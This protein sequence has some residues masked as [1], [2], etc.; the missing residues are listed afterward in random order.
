MRT[1]APEELEN[2][3]DFV[4]QDHI[5]KALHVGD[6]PFGKDAGTC[7]KHLLADFHVSMKP[8]LE[9]LLDSKK[10]KVLIYSGQL[11][12]IIGAALTERFLP[13]VKWFGQSDYASSERVIWKVDES[14]SEVAG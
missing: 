8:R 12:I 10:Y 5:R 7:E 1:N 13:T 9:V 14:D 3:A 11:D 2:Y 4:N 6:T